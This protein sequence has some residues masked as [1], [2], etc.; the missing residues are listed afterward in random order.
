[1]AHRGVEN[2]TYTSSAEDILESESDAMGYDVASMTDGN[3]Y[4][5][6]FAARAPCLCRARQRRRHGG[7]LRRAPGVADIEA[8]NCR[9]RRRR[10]RHAPRHPHPRCGAAAVLLLVAPALISNT[11]SLLDIQPPLHNP[12]HEAS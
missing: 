6:E 4:S 8:E 9:N 3:P 12:H 5:S 10:P 11:V 2:F 7:L 1:M